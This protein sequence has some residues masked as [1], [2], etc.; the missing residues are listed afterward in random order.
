[1]DDLIN[2]NG[3]SEDTKAKILEMLAQE[4]NNRNS[5][6]YLEQKQLDD[7]FAKTRAEKLN[8]AEKKESKEELKSIELDPDQKD[9][10]SLYEKRFSNGEVYKNMRLKH[11]LAEA[12]VTT[13]K[14][15]E[16]IHKDGL[17]NF[18]QKVKGV[19]DS[20]VV[21]SDQGVS[22]TLSNDDLGF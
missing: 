4:K 3:V 21:L 22:D 12:D 15:L 10:S 19:I 6:G 14:Q 13:Y 20:K 5:D 7:F 8:S 2:L 1:M 18:W 11:S 17:V 16:I 9:M